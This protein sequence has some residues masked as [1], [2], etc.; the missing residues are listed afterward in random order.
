MQSQVTSL[1][2]R[3]ARRRETQE[4]DVVSDGK[5]GQPKQRQRRATVLCPEGCGKLCE[6]RRDVNKHRLTRTV[7]ENVSLIGPVPNRP[8]RLQLESTL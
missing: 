8:S 5:A 4:T 6:S 7:P 1:G 2:K 3:L